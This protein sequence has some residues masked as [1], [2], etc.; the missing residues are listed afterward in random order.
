[1]YLINEFIIMVFI[2]YVSICMYECV[3][4]YLSS[5]WFYACDKTLVSCTKKHLV[6]FLHFSGKI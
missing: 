5:V 4:V 6:F 3:F 2:I 1:M